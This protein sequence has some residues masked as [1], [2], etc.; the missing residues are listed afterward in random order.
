MERTAKP[1]LALAALF[2]SEF[3]A[4]FVASVEVG[5]QLSL[6]DLCEIGEAE[7]HG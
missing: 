6:L 5:C 2:E 1:N 7:R 3:T 4:E